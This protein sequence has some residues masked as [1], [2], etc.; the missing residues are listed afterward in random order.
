MKIKI[1]L[2]I[3]LLTL[4]SATSTFSQDENIEN[5]FKKH[6]IGSSLLLL[7]NF[8][9]NPPDYYQINYGYRFTS[10]DAILVDFVTWKMS[11]PKGVPYGPSFDSPDEKF[12]GY[13]RESG[14]DVAYQ[15]FLWKGLNTSLHA[16]PLFQN[17]RNGDKEKI[18]NGFQ[19]FL[20]LRFGYHINL[21]KQRVFIEPTLAFNYWPVTTNEPESFKI[22][23]NRWPNYF[24][25][26][27]NIHF[28]INF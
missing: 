4:L 2:W 18:Q 12:P 20:S 10:K 25:F 5:G 7:S 1:E 9:P 28:G 11:S 19:L 15:R 23:E 13:I 26:D 3:L 27:P 24:L 16:T 17:Y 8:A 22:I 6:F 14:I 21:W